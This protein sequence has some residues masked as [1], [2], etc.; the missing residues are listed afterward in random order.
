MSFFNTMGFLLRL[1]L[2]IAISTWFKSPA[3]IITPIGESLIKFWMVLRYF[4]LDEGGEYVFINVYLWPNISHLIIKNLPSGSETFDVRLNG[5]ALLIKIPT[6]L[7][8]DR[9]I[10]M[11]LLL[12]VF[13]GLRWSSCRKTMSEESFY[14]CCKTFLLF[15]PVLYPINTF[16][17]TCFYTIVIQHFIWSVWT[18][19]SE[20]RT[21]MRGLK[22]NL[23]SDKPTSKTRRTE[24]KTNTKT[25]Y[26]YLS[27]TQTNTHKANQTNYNSLV[28]TN[29]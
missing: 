6:P 20:F 12:I 24:T 18:T 10:Q 14:K 11:P 9:L 26:I 16:V 28:L 7:L 27:L 2:S 15:Y 23:Y 1:E 29:L 17:R 13:Q 21:D 22:G 3:N 19:I 5:S 8:C 4:I 25:E